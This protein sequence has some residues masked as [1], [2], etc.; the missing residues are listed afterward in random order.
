MISDSVQEHEAQLLVGT[1]LG[2]KWRLDGLI[3]M[4]GMASVYSATHRNGRRVA[5]KL[6][7]AEFRRGAEVCDRFLREGYVA[8]RIG[9]PGVVSILDDDTTAS[10]QVY[11]VMELLEGDSFLAR[12]QKHQLT[13]AQVVFIGQQ[14]LE[15]LG[16]AHRCGI[17]HRDIKPGNVFVCNDGRVK[18]LDFGLARL[19]EGSEIEPSRDGLVRG[20]VPY[21][22]PEQASAGR[23]AVDWRSDI[24]GVGAMLFYALSGHYVHDGDSQFDMLMAA[25][26]NPARSLSSVFPAAPA[27]IVELVDRALRYDP[28]QRWQCAEDMAEAARAAFQQITG[29]SIPLTERAEVDGKKGWARAAL[30]PAIL[31]SPVEGEVVV[32][33]DKSIAVSVLFEPDAVTSP[34]LP[35]DGRK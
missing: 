15:P 7:N 12:I 5:I 27:K 25:T 35:V 13:P 18:I 26:K 34:D 29:T 1:V 4:G 10:G 8:N 32:L 31:K 6:L 3:G 20:T 22:S 16:V 23:D 24:Y 30:T 21:L 9:H 28:A 2:G 19:F 33:H 11:L 14:V 17:I